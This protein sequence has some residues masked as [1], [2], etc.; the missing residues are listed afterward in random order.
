M[1]SPSLENQIKFGI[2]VTSFGIIIPLRRIRKQTF[3]NGKLILAKAN[4]ASAPKMHVPTVTTIA[5][6]RLFA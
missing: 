6:Y 2:I 3:L 5:M 4:P 1:T